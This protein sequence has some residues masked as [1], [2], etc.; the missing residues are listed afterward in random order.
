MDKT[1]PIM[2]IKRFSF[3]LLTILVGCQAPER[4]HRLIPLYDDLSKYHRAVTTVSEEAQAYFDQGLALMYGF[5]HEAAIRS[6]QQAIALDSNCVMAWWGQAVSAGPNINNPYMDSTAKAMAW[7]TIEQ[8]RN[9]MNGASPVEQGLISAVAAR[10][11]W[12]PPDNRKSLDTAY[13]VAMEK[14]YKTFPGDP[15]LAVYYAD[16]LMNLRPWDLWTPDGQAQPETPV[17]MEVL[18]KVMAEQPDHPGACHLYIHIMEAS[19]YPEKALPAANVLRDRIPG[20]GHLVH[21]PSHIDIRLGHYQDA[22]TANARAIIADSIWAPQGGFYTMYRAHNHHFLAYAAMFDGQRQ[23]AL[24]AARE[25]VDQIPF[26]LV[27]AYPDFLDGFI[28][29]PYHVMVRFGMWDE[30]ITEPAPPED[31]YLTM[32]FWHYARAVAFAALGRVNES[33]TSYDALAN[34]YDS[35]PESR[36][37]GNNPG[38][39]VLDIGLLMAKGELEYRKGNYDEAFNLLRQAVVLDDALRYDEPWGWMMPVRHAL[40]ALL[41]EQEQYD[42]AV[43]VFLEDLRLH[44][45]N[46]WALK[47]LSACYHKT[48]NH[49]E[50]KKTDHRFAEAWSR[51]D[52]NLEV[53]C[54]CSRGKAPGIARD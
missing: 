15:E 49:E 14:V 50:A 32:A 27:R 24:E 17:I 40:G 21:M 1:S 48:G 42:E 29:V 51:S 6:F 25:M 20:A 5:N 23:K 22:I 2:Q 31:F 13:A 34:A 28:A 36:L 8:V 26:D 39:T 33:S 35:V 52:I 47:G 19:P 38:K 54:F 43:A 46:G 45:G 37:I 12:P 44:P 53:A 7:A 3:I 18:E 16:A 41:T 30:L 4:K 10:Y 11:A 9:R